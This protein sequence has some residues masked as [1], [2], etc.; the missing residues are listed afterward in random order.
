MKFIAIEKSLNNN[1][2]V[3][4]LFSSHLFKYNYTY[5]NHDRTK[6]VPQDLCH[7]YQCILHS[8]YGYQCTLH[9]CYGYQCILHGCHGY[10]RTRTWRGNNFANLK[11]ATANIAHGTVTMAP[12]ALCSCHGNHSENSAFV[13]VTTVHTA[14][15]I[16]DMFST[17]SMVTM[18]TLMNFLI[19]LC[20]NAPYKS[21]ATQKRLLEN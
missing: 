2:K 20:S 6:H 14:L 12:R 19:F 15:H 9:S 11:V 13:T 21:S 4:R 5:F 3:S 16:G 8:C 1:V 18:V 7:R 17:F 10:Y